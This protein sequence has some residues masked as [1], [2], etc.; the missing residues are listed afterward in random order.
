MAVWRVILEE[1][2]VLAKKRLQAA[3]T[4]LEKI[5]EPVKPLKANKQ[6]CLKKV[7]VGL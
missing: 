3:E 4:Y 5:A 1:T 2:D 7:S 6:Q